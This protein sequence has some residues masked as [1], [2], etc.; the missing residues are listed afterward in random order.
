MLQAFPAFSFKFSMRSMN[1]FRSPNFMWNSSFKSSVLKLNTTVEKVKGHEG[2]WIT[3]SGTT[4]LSLCENKMT[5]HIWTHHQSSLILQAAS[6]EAEPL[7]RLPVHGSHPPAEETQIGSTNWK[8]P[9]LPTLLPSAT[10][11]FGRLGSQ[12]LSEACAR[13]NSRMIPVKTFRFRNNSMPQRF[14]RQ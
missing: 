12:R 4:E 8:L 2:T 10:K 9:Q 5:G 11:R 3:G 1:F 13:M 6:A 7:H 14:R